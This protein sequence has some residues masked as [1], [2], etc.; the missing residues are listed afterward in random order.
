CGPRLPRLPRR[1]S[2]HTFA[3]HGNDVQ[4]LRKKVLHLKG[5]GHACCQRFACSGAFPSIVGIRRNGDCPGRYLGRLRAGDDLLQGMQ[6]VST[7]MALA[8]NRHRRCGCGHHLGYPI[9]GRHVSWEYPMPPVIDPEPTVSNGMSQTAI[10]VAL[11]VDIVAGAGG[12]AL[13]TTNAVPILGF[14]TMVAMQL[15]AMLQQTRVAELAA[16]AAV[17]ADKVATVAVEA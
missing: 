3:L 13:S 10:L 12:A 1:R 8:G 9:R 16:K 7:P 17:K 2:W 4:T 11:G 6:Y 14:C 15:L 5:V